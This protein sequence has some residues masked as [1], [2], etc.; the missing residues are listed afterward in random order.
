MATTIQGK[1]RPAQIM[2]VALLFFLLS[3]SSMAQD[4][5]GKSS[6]PELV[7]LYGQIAPLIIKAENPYVK[8]SFVIKEGT[9]VPL[10]FRCDRVRVWVKPN[11]IIYKPPTIG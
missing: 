1:V 11:G 9:V 7:G 2:A 4:C 5:K 10:D 8:E 6:W 3:A